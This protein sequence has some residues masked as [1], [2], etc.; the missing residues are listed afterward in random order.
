MIGVAF[1]RLFSGR[2]RRAAGDIDVRL[3]FWSQLDF[4]LWN[5]STANFCAESLR[6]EHRKD[7]L[8]GRPDRLALSCFDPIMSYGNSPASSFSPYFARS[9]RDLGLYAI[10]A[11]YAWSSGMIGLSLAIVGIFTGDFRTHRTNRWDGSVRSHAFTRQF[12]GAIGMLV[13]GSSARTSAVYIASIP[14]ISSGH[15][16]PGSAEA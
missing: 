11:I 13:A 7:Q 8:R 3:P 6:D 15:F 2:N 5:C 9:V 4:S 12:F 1:V 16:V 10:Y 14:I